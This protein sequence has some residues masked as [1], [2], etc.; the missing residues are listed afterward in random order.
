[1][2]PG[3]RNDSRNR[4]SQYKR[5]RCCRIDK[6]ERIR[7]APTSETLHSERIGPDRKVKDSIFQRLQNLEGQFRPTW[8]SQGQ[9]EVFAAYQRVEVQTSLTAQRK[10]VAVDPIR[11]GDGSIRRRPDDQSN[12]RRRRDRNVPRDL[13]GETVVVRRSLGDR[14]LDQQCVG[15]CFFEC[16]GIH[17]RK[18]RWTEYLSTEGIEETP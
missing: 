17:I 2:L 9:N 14:T 15:A 13:Y 8:T 18:R 3:R 16:D 1:M 7:A 6:P 12:A 5:Q 11:A 4:R 10:V